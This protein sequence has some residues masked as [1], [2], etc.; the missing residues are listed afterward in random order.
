MKDAA[1]SVWQS[2]RA[3]LEAF[4][5]S[6]PERYL[7]SNAPEAICAHA[8]VAMDRARERRSV[9]AALVPSR[10]PEVSELCVVAE[11][12]PGPIPSNARSVSK[13]A[14]VGFTFAQVA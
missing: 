11:D 4:L 5:S 12:K 3:D 1:L 14:S 9:Q 8:R 7:L 2:K 6:M 13:R 10:H